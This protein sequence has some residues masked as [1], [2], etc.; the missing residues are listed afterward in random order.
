MPNNPAIAGATG[1]FIA[2]RNTMKT[3]ASTTG[4]ATESKTFA[5]RV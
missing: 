2:T 5:V 1:L 4:A 3:T